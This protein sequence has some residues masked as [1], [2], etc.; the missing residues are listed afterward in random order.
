MSIDFG[1][2]GIMVL[3]M[4]PNVVEL[5][6]WM[7]NL[8]WFHDMLMRVWCIGTTSATQIKSPASLDSAADDMINLI[9]WAMIMSTSFSLDN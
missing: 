2:L 8:G 7:G 5:S 4:V 9:N 3:F 6:V 1:C